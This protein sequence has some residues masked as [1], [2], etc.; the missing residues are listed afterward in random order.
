MTRA[1][2]ARS[3]L[4]HLL[5]IDEREAVISFAQ[6]PLGKLVLFASVLFLLLL[7]PVAK[8]LDPPLWVL[9]LVGAAAA[10]A[11][12]PKYR[13][14][15]LFVSTWL[16][17]FLSLPASL[18]GFASLAILMVCCWG[19]LQYVQRYKTHLYARRPVVT[20]LAILALLT[21]LASALP[22][23]TVQDLTWS[24]VTVSSV[25]IWFLSY[26]IM[27]QRSRHAKPGGA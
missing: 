21:A 18:H 6:K 1:K 24:F 13:R 22:R 7:P 9:L 14:P 17:A 26:A 11:Y 10:H 3:P 16:I 12:L 4:R 27:D 2:Q 19:S 25:Y 5:A 15:V 23:G 20:L 8:R